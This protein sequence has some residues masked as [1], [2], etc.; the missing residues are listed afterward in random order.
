[1][2]IYE[3][4]FNL[5]YQLLPVQ[6]WPDTFT[7][8]ERTKSK[9]PKD[10]RLPVLACESVGG[11]SEQAIPAVAAIGCMQISIILVDDML[12]AD[13]RGMHN[14]FG[15]PKTS[16]MAVAFQSAGLEAITQSEAEPEN[17]LAALHSLSEMMLT[18]AFGQHMDVRNP[19]DE[20]AYWQLVRTKSSPFFG[21]A[22]HVGAVLGSAPTDTSE[23]IKLLGHIYGEMI[24][25][26]DDLNDTMAVPA[27]PDWTLGRSPL[28]ILYAQTVE[29]PE[30]ERFLELRQAIPDPEAL[31]EAQSIL[32]R[33]GAVSYAVDRLIRRYQAAL[34]MLESMS[35]IKPQGLEKLLDDVID[36]VRKLFAS[37]GVAESDVLLTPLIRSP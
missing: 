15:A 16:N 4:T 12:D 23:Q 24:Q 20:E 3:P 7:I 27:N 30:R 19:K 8:L 6:E 18:T 31:T 36:P 14:Q 5:I 29:H 1:M 34:D 22:L 33:C 35:R 10:W 17:K 2:D 26:H 37:I 13:P 25:I 21:A 11:L 32:I 9:K 28:P